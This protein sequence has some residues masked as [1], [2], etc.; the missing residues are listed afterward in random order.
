MV[1]YTVPTTGSYI[2]TALG[3]GGGGIGGSGASLSG[4]INLSA[5]TVLDIWVGQQPIAGDEGSGG[6]GGSFVALNRVPSAVPESGS[7]L[8]LLSLALGGV[9]A[10]RGRMV[11]VRSV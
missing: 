4:T 2:I 8:L 7:S 9:A 3:A 10:L 5:G 6:G 1:Q 11:R